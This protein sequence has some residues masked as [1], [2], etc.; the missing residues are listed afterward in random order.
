MGIT[1]ERALET[2]R[3]GDMLILVDAATR[4]NEGDLVLAAA[5]ATPDAVNF[6]ITHGRGLVCAPMT[7][8]WAERLDLPPMCPESRDP[9]GAR[10]AVSVDAREG[11]ATGT[12][13]QDRARTIGCLADAATEPNDLDRPGHIFPLIARD[14]GVLRRPGHTEASVDLM[15]LAGLAPVA[16]LCEILNEDGTMARPPQL[17]V[18]AERHGLSIVRIADLIAYRRAQEAARAGDPTVQSVVNEREE[19]KEVA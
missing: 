17:A 12:S 7:A 5:H 1:I 4:E 18:F 10:F 13:T 15:R 19:R 8:A 14:G 16:V 11:T 3:E 2:L 6:M 9:H